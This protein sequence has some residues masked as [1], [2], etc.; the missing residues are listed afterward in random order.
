MRDLHV[1]LCGQAGRYQ[2]AVAGLR[3]ALHAEEGRRALGGQGGD[4]R[5]EV[6]RVQDLPG[7]TLA[8]GGGQHGSGALAHSSTVVVG[9]LEPAQLGRGR[10]LGV[11]AVRDARLGES[12]L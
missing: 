7:V 6:R 4:E 12:R 2:G 10:Q 3:V 5:L 9:V 8:E 11:V 1:V